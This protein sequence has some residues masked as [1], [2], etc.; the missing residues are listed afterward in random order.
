MNDELVIH[1]RQLTKR[2]G[3]LTAV[4]HLDLDVP[5][6]IIYGFLGPNGSGKTTAIRMLCGLL[7]PTEGGAT[8]LGIDV[9]TG[10][11][12]LKSRIGY[13]TQKF[14]L[15]SD[16]TVLENLRFVADI[17]AYPQRGRN[18]RIGDLIERYDLV[19]QQK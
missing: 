5:R 4:D 16:L 7:T 18:A 1:A 11:A 10:A 17:Y 13:M 3:A 19:A 2:F 12:A 6:A 14:S 9:P 8:V 15:Y